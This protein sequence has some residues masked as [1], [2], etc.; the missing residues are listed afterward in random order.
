MMMNTE[1]SL[2]G[3]TIPIHDFNAALTELEFRTAQWYRANYGESCRLC[4]ESD[5]SRQFMLTMLAYLMGL[6]RT[7]GDVSVPLVLIA[8]TM[9]QTGYSIGRKRA[10]AEILEGWLRL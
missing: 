1:D 6:Q 2:R 4:V 8:A 5:A 7:G 3:Q 9:L 10:E